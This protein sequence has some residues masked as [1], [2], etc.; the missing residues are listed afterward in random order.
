M[1]C[2]FILSFSSLLLSGNDVVD[3]RA[4]M[5]IFPLS[6]ILCSTHFYCFVF[7]PN[8]IQLVWLIVSL[9]NVALIAVCNSAS[10][11]IFIVSSTCSSSSRHWASVSCWLIAGT[12]C[13]CTLQFVMMQK[14]VDFIT[15]VV[16]KAKCILVMAICMSVSV[17]LCVYRS[18]SSPPRIPTPLHG[19]GCNL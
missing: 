12:C 3:K 7:H 16:G 17:C 10:K 4:Q 2:H 6:V 14:C 8:V 15:W 18:V 1:F 11:Y 9:A 5:E 19:P 13:K